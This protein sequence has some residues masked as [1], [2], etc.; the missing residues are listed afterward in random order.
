MKKLVSLLVALL[1]VLTM[2]SAVAESDVTTVK[3]IVPSDHLEFME[4]LFVPFMEA[5]PDIKVEVDG[6]ANGWDGVSTKVITML[7]GGEQVD[8]AAVST[9]YYPQF[10]SLGQLLD[11]T[12]HAKETYSEDEYYWSVFD[13]LMIDGRL[14]GVPISVYTLVNY[15]NKDMY[16]AASV[17]YPSLEWGESA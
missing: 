4:Q 1:M 8:I 10:A 16:D 15:I 5:N 2:A 7:A 14:Y 9:S 13:G 6:T 17:A 11:I 3:L 12:D